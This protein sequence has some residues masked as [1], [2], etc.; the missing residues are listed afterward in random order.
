MLSVINAVNITPYQAFFQPDQPIYSP[1]IC[2]VQFV[3]PKTDCGRESVVYFESKKFYFEKAYK[4]QRFDF[5]QDTLFL[6]GEIRIIFYGMPQ[7][8]TLEADI[9]SHYNDFY[10][11]ISH[12]ELCG[13][14]LIGYNVGKTQINNGYSHE[15]G[16]ISKR[17]EDKIY[18]RDKD[19]NSNNT[20]LFEWTELCKKNSMNLKPDLK[21][22]KNPN[23]KFDI[24]IFYIERSSVVPERDILLAGLNTYDQKVGRT[25]VVT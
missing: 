12:V 7:R 17:L 18:L 5:D 14:F 1:V 21:G 22:T 25:C 11:C 24:L 15:I 6:G 10:I 8:Q 4:P 3:L 9:G 2:F 19:D 20:Q 23:P 16:S 13:R